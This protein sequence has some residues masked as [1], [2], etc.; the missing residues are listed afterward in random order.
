MKKS[1]LRILRSLFSRPSFNIRLKD[2]VLSHAAEHL[3]RTRAYIHLH[4]LQK[5]GAAIIDVGAAGGD[6]T[7]WFAKSFPAHQVT[8]FEPLT[9]SYDRAVSLTARCRN[10]KMLNCAL[11]ES[12][13]MA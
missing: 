12:S 7:L 11:D 6:T 9:E 5:Y 3:F 2:A 10:V 1:I 13:G 4:G 8:G